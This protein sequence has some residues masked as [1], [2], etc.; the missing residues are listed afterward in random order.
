LKSIIEA[1]KNVVDI[2]F[3]AEEAFELNKLAKDKNVTAIVDCGVVPGLSG[4]I[5]GY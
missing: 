4:I 2:S 5:L 1:G 3:F